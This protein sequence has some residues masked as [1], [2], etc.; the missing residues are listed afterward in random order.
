[1]L[2]YFARLLVPRSPS[3]PSVD[4]R[5][6]ARAGGCVTRT[7]ARCARRTLRGSAQ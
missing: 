1:M 2:E 5:P 6:F 3:A 4:Y 7:M